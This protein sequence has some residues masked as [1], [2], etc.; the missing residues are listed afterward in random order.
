MNYEK[1]NKVVQTAI[2]FLLVKISGCSGS[3]PMLEV[4]KM[5]ILTKKNYFKN[6]SQKSSYC[7]SYM[8]SLKM[9]LPTFKT[10]IFNSSVIFRK[11]F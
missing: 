3:A 7:S 9:P 1:K 10:C 2:H 8:E 11:I 4:K 5:F 6:C